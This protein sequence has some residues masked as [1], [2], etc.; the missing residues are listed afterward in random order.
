[1][2]IIPHCLFLIAYPTR[3][4]IIHFCWYFL[5][6]CSKDVKS[7]VVSGKLQTRKLKLEALENTFANLWRGH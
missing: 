7:C 5:D 1:M 3:E 6:I 4:S 2:H